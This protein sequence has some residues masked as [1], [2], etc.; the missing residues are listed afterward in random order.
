MS[1]D[2][3]WLDEGKTTC[4]LQRDENWTW[5]EFDTANIKSNELIKQVPHQVDLVVAGV[6]R[7]PPGNPIR[8]FQH[9]LMSKPDNLRSLIVVISNPFGRNIFN[10]MSKLRN[11]K[12]RS[13]HAARS[14]EE[15]LSMVQIPEPVM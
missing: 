3:K 14:F 1:I 9:A 4:L 6:D 11:K 15:A 13:M 7:L 5:E 10:V 8:H 12:A 2:V